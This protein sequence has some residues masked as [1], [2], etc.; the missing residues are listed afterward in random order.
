MQNPGQSSFHA[1]TKRQRPSVA[2]VP[3]GQSFLWCGSRFISVWNNVP[4]C[5]PSTNQN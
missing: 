1:S 4:S 5:S 3:S 2:S